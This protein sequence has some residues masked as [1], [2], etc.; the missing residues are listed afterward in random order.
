MLHG[1]AFPQSE[2][3]A[4]LV[5]VSPFFLMLVNVFAE[6]AHAASGFAK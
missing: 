5:F 2:R 1:M 3:A 6:D 4:A